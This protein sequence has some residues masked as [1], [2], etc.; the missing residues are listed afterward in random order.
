MK[1]IAFVISGLNKTGG[2]ETVVK[3]IA[4]KLKENYEI[5]TI[6][7]DNVDNI[8][9]INFVARKYDNVKEK[10]VSTCIRGIN[11]YTNLLSYNYNILEKYY[12]S[13]ETQKK[14]LSIL[15]DY[16]IDVCIGVAGY[17]SM[18]LG[19]I[20]PYT[21]TKCIGWQHNSYEA[22]FENKYRYLW[23]QN[24]LFSKLVNNLDSYV[25]LNQHDAGMLSQSLGVSCNV[26]VN[27]RSFETDNI[28]K[29][30]N[31]VF[32]AAGRL[33]YAKGFD[34]LIEAFSY[35]TQKDGEWKL[36]IYGE[37]EEKNHLKSLISKYKMEDRIMLMGNTDDIQTA[38]L[39]ASVFCLSSRWEGMP[40]I[41]LEA[42]EMGVPIVAFD[43]TAMEPL[44]DN[45]ING[46]IVDAY[47]SRKFA[48]AM[49]SIAQSNEI[50]NSFGK[51]A[52]EKAKC[53]SLDNIIVQWEN[54]IS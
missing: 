48:N 49:L 2:I 41:I 20:A 10:L 22:Y 19:K 17:N 39:D 33:T 31:K 46:I 12:F 53:F 16:N 42:L 52:R 5:V 43:I 34:I 14:L 7:V 38:F 36:K 9:N 44:V 13:K 3:V 32:M 28:S 4:L 37:G 35:F 29:L 27:P 26:I 6:G 47:N 54:L 18:L 23:H 15:I 11:K 30:E 24:T 25:V 1:K 45:E 8:N 51:K 21:R 40:M 50:R